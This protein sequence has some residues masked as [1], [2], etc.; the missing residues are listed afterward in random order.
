M[1]KTGLVFSYLLLK[2]SLANDVINVSLFAGPV[3][4]EPRDRRNFG[5]SL[6]WF[7][8]SVILYADDILLL[9]PT[10]TSL[11]QLLHVC[12]TELAWLDVN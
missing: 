8:L 4:C 2:E 9:A 10:V 6:K 11:Q 7:C 1:Y 3:C 5:C 12:E